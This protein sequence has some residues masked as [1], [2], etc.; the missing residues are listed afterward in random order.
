MV[1]TGALRRIFWRFQL[2]VML[3]VHFRASVQAQTGNLFGQNFTGDV[4]TLSI[5][6]SMP[7]SVEFS[8]GNVF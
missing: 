6:C 4:S 2:C 3:V 1:E 7:D 5:L 8:P